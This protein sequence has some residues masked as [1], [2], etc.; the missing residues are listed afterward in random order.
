MAGEASAR[1]RRARV[2]VPC[3]RAVWLLVA[4]AASAG[5][6]RGDEA[7]RTQD[8][9]E[10]LYNR[11]LQSARHT[12]QQATSARS[13][14]WMTNLAIDP[15][16][17]AVNDLVTVR[18]VESI[19]AQGSADS[20]LTKSSRATAAVPRLF[21]L[22]EALPDWLDPTALVDAAAETR[23][24]GGG[25]T[26]RSGELSATITARVVEVLPNGDLVLE[27]AREIDINGDRQIVV[28]TGVVRQVDIDRNNR[29]LSTAIGQLRI[30]YFGRGLI[31]DNLRPGLLVRILN[32]IF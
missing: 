3:G 20:Q 15:R 1:E 9:Y 16:A 26:T 22:E 5:T 8:S 11:Y 32:K 18:V 24:K 17:R 30:Q 7:R 10:A 19:V 13:I 2:G 25:V 6:A 29:V 27:G 4:L 14:A 28:L 23:F 31:R 12:E 21:G